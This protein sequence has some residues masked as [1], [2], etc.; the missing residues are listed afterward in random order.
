M[1]EMLTRATGVPID[2]VDGHAKVTGAA[3]YAYEYPIKD[4]AY[5]CPVQSTI[6]AGRITSIDV[7][8]AAA[9]PG[10]LAVLTHDNAPRLRVI[11]PAPP[12][13][14]DVEV[15][16]LQTDEVTYRGQFVAAVVAGSLEA[17]QEAA[18][19]VAVEYQQY[20]HSVTLR[21]DDDRLFRPARL[22]NGDPPDTAT[23][24]TDR[25]LASASVSIDATYTTPACHHNPMEP[26]A[27]IAIWSGDGLT[28][29]DSNQGPHTIRAALATAF[30]LPIERIRVI[31]PYVGGGFGAKGLP[32]PHLTLTAMAAQVVG[33]PVKLALTRQQMFAV[34]GYRTPTIQRVRLG[35]D[36]SGTLTALSHDVVEQTSLRHEFVQH[37]AVASRL[38][39]AAP[40]L[41]TTHRVARLNVPYPTTMRGPGEAPGM[42]ALESAM[43]ELAA[44]CGVDPVQLRIHNVPPAD[45]GTGLPFSSHGLAQCLREGAH[46]FGWQHR[47]ARRDGRWLIGSG[48][49]ASTY[50]VMTWPATALI[51]VDHAGEFQVLIG[52]SDIGTGARTVLT[53]IAADAL[54]QPLHRVHVRLGDTTLPF[55]SAAAGAT[56]T[57]SWGSAIVHA[58][59]ILRARMTDLDGVV[60]ADGL[61]ARGE[62]Q[63]NPQSEHYSMHSFGAQFAEVKVDADTGEVRV[64]RLVGVFAGGRIIN[65]KT[66]RSQLLGGMTMGVSMALHEASILDTEFGDYLNHNLADYHIAV[67]ADIGDIDVSWI[68]EHDPH[69]N[70]MGTKGIGEIGIV[71]T[72]AAIANGV[73]HAT[74][75]RVRD[76]PILPDRLLTARS[77]GP[78]SM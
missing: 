4:I 29:Y 57:G 39:Y 10:V 67:N 43:D 69:I 3:T 26:Q 1:T 47:A 74:G 44:A 6:A 32:H 53:Q 49:A 58:A 30:G 5:V 75:I 20:Q 19:L 22:F 15:E 45:P 41:A 12:R 17:A 63:G 56:G 52:A 8:S 62:V 65:P 78:G 27:T 21:A 16:A 25:A 46:R 60:P 24:D 35:A 40:N 68:D 11:K 38:M 28:L 70:P 50:P 42:F 18:R 13:F 76:L 14:I 31:S 23:G 55:A 59:S 9:L 48:V 36:P 33:R 73:A 72:A 51:R 7:S 34:G 64:A 37:T 61:E 66:A 54:D 77:W 2:R 71:G